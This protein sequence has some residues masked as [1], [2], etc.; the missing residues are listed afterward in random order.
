MRAVSPCCG[1]GSLGSLGPGS[2]TYPGN[3]ASFLRSDNMRSTNSNC[4]DEDI[5]SEPHGRRKERPVCNQEN[6]IILQHGDNIYQ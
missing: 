4:C 3:P 1:P 5:L 2:G 6:W